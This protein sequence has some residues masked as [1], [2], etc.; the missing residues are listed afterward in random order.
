MRRARFRVP[1]S[2][3]GRGRWGCGPFC[4]TSFMLARKCVSAEWKSLIFRA[5]TAFLYSASFE[6]DKNASAAKENVDALRAA[7]RIF[8][9]SGVAFS[10]TTL[11]SFDTLSISAAETAILLGPFKDSDAQQEFHVRSRPDTSSCPVQATSSPVQ[12]CLSGYVPLSSS[13]LDVTRFDRFPG[14]FQGNMFHGN[15][16]P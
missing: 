5:S 15:G 7:A 8:S 12:P 10:F 9:C 4:F 6:H 11:N 16:G 14:L 3:R 1:G 13:T 2:F